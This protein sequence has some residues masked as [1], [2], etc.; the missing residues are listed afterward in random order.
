[1]SVVQ[2][3][4]SALHHAVIGG[5]KACVNLLLDFKAWKDAPDLQG[6]TPVHKAAELGRKDCLMLLLANNKVLNAKQ[7][8]VQRTR[9]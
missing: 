3:G 4:M 7:V 8:G 6:R 5:H 1:M 9:S 2:R